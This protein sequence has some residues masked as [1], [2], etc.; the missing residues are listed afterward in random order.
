MLWVWACYNHGDKTIYVRLI[1]YFYGKKVYNYLLNKKLLMF[2]SQAL[3][4][5]HYSNRHSSVNV[6]FPS[7][8]GVKT[9]STPSLIFFYV[10][11]PEQEWSPIHRSSNTEDLI[12]RL[13]STFLHGIICCGY[14]LEASLWGNFNKFPNHMFLK[15]NKWK[16]LC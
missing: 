11:K 14:L 12:Q 8:I 10:H 3:N 2:P 15:I 9:F 4:L 5:R 6:N 1:M 13:I 16:F 7:K